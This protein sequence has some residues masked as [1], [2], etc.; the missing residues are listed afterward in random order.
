MK[1]SF[2]LFQYL[3]LICIIFMGCSSKKKS[4]NTNIDII[5]TANHEEKYNEED[6]C[7]T[8]NPTPEVKETITIGWEYEVSYDEE[9][10]DIPLT[11]V[12]L[13]IKGETS[14]REYVGEYI[15][16]LENY[17]L[18]DDNWGFPEDSI[19]ASFGWYAGS[20]DLLSV[21]REESGILSVKHKVIAESG[22]DSEIQEE[23]DNYTFES[24]LSIQISEDALI[25]TFN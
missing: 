21:V 15:G 10:F 4:A 5:P 14:I 25:E 1:K 8:N 18:S 16:E 9:N 17:S 12:Y 2:I 20:G 13:V 24:I 19:I 6:V 23:L 3:I 22:G 11:K 7:V